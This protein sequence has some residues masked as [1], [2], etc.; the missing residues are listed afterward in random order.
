MLTSHLFLAFCVNGF[1]A[2]S[3]PTC[4]CSESTAGSVNISCTIVYADHPVAP[5]NA[6]MSCTA[7]GQSYTGTTPL[8]TLV[9]SSTPQYVW[10]STPYIIAYN[11]GPTTY[12]CITTFSAPVGGPNYIAKNVPDFSAS[13]QGKLF[14]Q[15]Y[16]I[17][18]PHVLI[19]ITRGNKKKT[20]PHKTSKR[21]Y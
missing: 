19:S 2:G 8:R 13:R 18:T 5:I 14:M 1:L 4:S 10:N 20:T 11:T 9:P 15:R 17:A 21:K 3:G 12:D 6:V 16:F 7:N